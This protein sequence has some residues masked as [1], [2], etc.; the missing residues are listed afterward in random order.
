MQTIWSW[1]RIGSSSLN[2]IESESIWWA[3]GLANASSSTTTWIAV[4]LSITDVGNP[5][6]S[7]ENSIVLRLRFLCG[8]VTGVTTVSPIKST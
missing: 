8:L 4:K 5:V 1:G 2:V 7:S 6:G 3:G